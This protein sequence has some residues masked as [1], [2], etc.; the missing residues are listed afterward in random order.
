MT[1]QNIDLS[2]IPC[3]T[4]NEKCNQQYKFHC[5]CNYNNHDNMEQTIIL[6]V[7]R[8]GQVLNTSENYY[9]YLITKQGLQMNKTMMDTYNPIYDILI[10]ANPNIHNPF[11]NSLPAPTP[12]HPH[13]H[14]TYFTPLNPS[15]PLCPYSSPPP[16][17]VTR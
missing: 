17:P 10:K 4:V 12:L 1:S 6:H 9:I 13:S 16:Y 5:Q 7:E 11:Q 3:I 8:K 14:S 15:I 2:G